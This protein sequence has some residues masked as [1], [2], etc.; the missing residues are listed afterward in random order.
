MALQTKT[1]TAN[2]SKHHTFTLNVVENSTDIAN[3]TSNISW[4]FSISPTGAYD[5]Y[6]TNAPVTY[7]VTINGV[8]YTGSIAR[9][10]ATST[11]VLNS[12]STTITHNKDGNK[13][14]TVGFSVVT[15]NSSSYLP[16]N[17]SKNDT[18]T[19]TFIARKATLT[20]VPASFTDE[21]NLTIYY[22]NPAGNIVT[23][24]QTCL[25][26]GSEVLIPYRDIDKTGTSYTYNFTDE[27]RKILRQSVTGS[28]SKSLNI[29]VT[30]DING[31][32]DYV[33]SPITLN[34]INALPTL[35]PTVIDIGATSTAL[36]GNPN[37]MIR[38]FNHM[39][40]VANAEAYKEATITDRKIIN[41]GDI[42]YGE[43]ED[44]IH[45]TNNVFEFRINDSRNNPVQIPITIP[46]VN[47][48]PLT[49]NVDGSIELDDT[50]GTKANITFTISGNYFRGSFGAVDN[51][52]TLSYRLEQEG[53]NELNPFT[54]SLTIPEEAYGDGTYSLTY[55]HPEKL[56][57]KG[58]YT[59]TV[60]AADKIYTNLETSSKPLKAVPIF[61]W[62]ENDFNFNVPIKMYG[63]E[64]PYVTE[65][66]EKD[67][68]TYRKWSNG[69]AECWKMVEHT[70]SVTNTWGSMYYGTDVERQNY[71]F[72]FS[73]KPFEQVTM[74][75]GG[76]AAWLCCEGWGVNG[77]WASAIY[78]IISPVVVS[79][80]QTYYL[81]YYIKGNYE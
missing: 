1:L 24:L 14:I 45:T 61:D 78:S 32:Y 10:A 71:P 9:Y 2:G 74:L 23:T 50:D 7:T 56:D 29:Y 57:Y 70:T 5:W 49:C 51:T 58:R 17:A 6:Y 79:D 21:D 60:Y 73:S 66:G 30:T 72:P 81:N 47:Y 52:L 28:N 37:T 26:I 22:D 46:M 20:S 75:C 18:M 42:R 55:T 69:E 48:I 67:G 53:V 8:N 77:S 76:N 54:N 16:G 27:E 12:G 38:G 40:A 63:V 4:S 43:S 3:N 33:Y 35:N 64:M 41:S 15:N 80:A 36:T 25:A 68:W 11:V 34:I 62:G 39:R 44:F 59:I 65:Q 31:D 13:S 19:L